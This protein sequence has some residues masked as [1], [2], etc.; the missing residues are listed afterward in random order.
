MWG[1]YLGGGSNGLYV[2]DVYR[3]DLGVVSGDGEM[4]VDIG[5]V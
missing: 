1:Y 3:L 5:K 2:I 4:V